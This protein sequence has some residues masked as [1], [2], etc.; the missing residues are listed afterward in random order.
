MG[1]LNIGKDSSRRRAHIRFRRALWG[2]AVLIVAGCWLT[3]GCGH[4]ALRP[5]S[6]AAQLDAEAPN[7]GAPG[8]RFYVMVFAAQSVPR[9]P[10]HSHT[11]ATVV[12]AME[13]P[14]KPPVLEAFTISWMPATLDIHPLRFTVEPGTNL[15]LHETMVYAMA[16]H[17]RISMWG[18]YECRPGFFQRF[19]IQKQ[20]LESGLVGYQCDDNW[21]EG[22]RTGRGFCCIHAIGDM[23]PEDGCR[24]YPHLWFGDRASE[25]IVNRLHERG[26]LLQPEIEQDWLIGAL[27][28]K[29]Y[30]IRRRHYQDCVLKRS[31]RSS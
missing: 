2:P 3:T 14:A 20:F 13:C 16:K 29:A 12:R 7:Y 18:P 27:G 17:E 4:Y 23:E 22:A 19:V 5:S 1:M 30:G 26:C 8:E 24:Y 11:W 28:L 25:H 31:P 15:G 9:L 6:P 10:S 21:G